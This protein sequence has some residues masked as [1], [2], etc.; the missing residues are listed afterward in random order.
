[1]F[2]NTNIIQTNKKYILEYNFILITILYTYKI[3]VLILLTFD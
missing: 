2:S 3:I 1:M